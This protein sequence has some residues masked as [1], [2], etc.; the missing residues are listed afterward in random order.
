MNRGG[1][2]VLSLFV[3]FAAQAGAAP[4]G[5]GKI[6]YSF[7][8]DIVVSDSDG[9]KAQRLALGLRPRWSPDGSTIAFLSPP[10]G[11]FRL[12][13]RDL[14]LIEPGGTGLRRLAV[15]ASAHSWSPDGTRIA[16]VS[17]DDDIY[18]VRVGDGV[19][20]RITSDGG[21]K[22]A[23]SW[24]PDGTRLTFGDRS[25]SQY[26]GW[27]IVLV[28]ADGSNRRT[29]P[30]GSA[31]DPVWAPDGAR[32]AFIRVSPGVQPRG[33]LF[34]VNVES[35]RLTQLS[36][37][38]AGPLP[39]V[40]SPDGQRILMGI[41]IPLGD[42]QFTHS[43]VF[44]VPADEP[45]PMMLVS[46]TR[47]RGGASAVWSP[48]GARIVFTSKRPG[49][50]QVFVANA[51]GTCPTQITAAGYR[52]TTSAAT[53]AWQPVPGGTPSPEYRCADL[54][55]QGRRLNRPAQARGRFSFELV[56][57]NDGNE[58]A[59]GLRVTAEVP[60]R[61]SLTAAI[62]ERGGRCGVGHRHL[63]C[64]FPALEVHTDAVIQVRARSSVA[65]KFTIVAS[66]TADQ[67]DG[68]GTNNGTRLVQEVSRCTHLG[69]NRDDVLRGTRWAD[70]ICPGPGSDRV[71]AGLGRDLVLVGDRT[72]D[73]IRCGPGRDQVFAD[74]LDLVAHDCE[75]VS[76]R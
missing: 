29:L 18:V 63:I 14:Y 6:A 43:E 64:S 40:W 38:L 72:R 36:D 21:A 42:P 41:S 60:P 34:S 54:A 70:V 10:G 71:L 24:S 32:I 1:L 65:G 8:T 16:F 55:L 28:D 50:S 45:D 23:P 3:L 68:D 52:L 35:L 27:S 37:E 17:L 53:P 48:D 22:S 12:E 4:T 31:R 20:T 56:V 67:R 74:R 61:L 9:T 76:R 66:A 19:L 58:R 30:M 47:G 15:E 44:L 5:N 33:A 25:A 59:T 73:V 69:S 7:G 26:A 49:Q 57:R 13:R 62:A 75:Q 51:D 46:A 2:L 11:D 39:P